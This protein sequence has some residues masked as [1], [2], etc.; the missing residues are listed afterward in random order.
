MKRIKNTSHMTAN[1]ANRTKV[2]V[3]KG[4]PSANFLLT[5]ANII[6]SYICLPALLATVS[7]CLAK[8]RP[9]QQR[10]LAILA[11]LAGK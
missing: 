6:E 10:I 2:P 1:V 4:P 5:L 3:N 8:A 7:N 9:S 11:V